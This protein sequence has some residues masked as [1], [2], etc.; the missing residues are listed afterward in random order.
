MN[1]KFKIF[2]YFLSFIFGYSILQNISIISKF[3]FFYFDSFDK[4]FGNLIFLFFEI[5]Y[6][7]ISIQFLTMSIVILNYLTEFWWSNGEFNQ[8]FKIF[9]ILI[10][11]FLIKSIFEFS[12][13]FSRDI[14]KLKMIGYFLCTLIIIYSIFK[15]SK[16]Y[17]K[18][19]NTSSSSTNEN[20][21][22][23]Q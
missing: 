16:L 20:E 7:N 18:V 11:P 13:R 4:T 5:F 1:T 6:L 2:F 3:Y 9:K 12:I 23:F 10:Q 14:L 21:K 17:Q 15:V 22:N 19:M 8:N